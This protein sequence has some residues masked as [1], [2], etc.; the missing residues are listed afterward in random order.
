MTKPFDFP[1]FV[2]SQVNYISNRAIVPIPSFIPEIPCTI[3]D[4]VFNGYWDRVKAHTYLDA[5]KAKRVWDL[6]VEAKDLEGD[7]IECGS[8]QGGLGF[9]LGF[10]IRHFGLKKRVFLCDS[11][12]GLPEP[13]PNF[14]SYYRKGM[15]TSDFE[16]CLAFIRDEGLQ[17]EVEVMPGWFE[18]TLPEVS[19]SRSFSL[20]HIDCDIYDST[21]TCLENLYPRASAKAPVIFDD[22]YV[23][24][25]GERLAA[26]EWISQ[27]KET[28]EV[29]PLSQVY[30]RKGV[31]VSDPQ[32]IVRDQDGRE[33][34]IRELS[35][36]RPYQ[37]FLGAV[38]ERLQTEKENLKNL[39]IR[40]N[41]LAR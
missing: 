13:N 6:A 19:I 22:F 18:E 21:R 34:S 4:P 25:P 37:E 20:V 17:N 7:F 29:G 32:W 2:L 39:L 33:L 16:K 24:P 11:F 23:P 38:L 30:L 35:E 10:F 14:D 15:L 41:P 36:N 27:S 5:Y 12:E 40:L 28:L 3:A 26:W 31:R 8:H 1:L 9:L